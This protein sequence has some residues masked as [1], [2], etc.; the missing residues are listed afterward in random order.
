MKHIPKPIIKKLDTYANTKNKI[1]YDKFK[2]H[3]LIF[4][5]CESQESIPTNIIYG[6]SEASLAPYI[7]L[8]MGVKLSLCLERGI[9][10]PKGSPF[11]YPHH[12]Q[13][14]SW[15]AQKVKGTKEI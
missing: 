9:F 12:E 10:F 1:N 6:A 15:D 11:N 7:L 5:I 8:K 2:K 13:H 3:K 4:I 14:M